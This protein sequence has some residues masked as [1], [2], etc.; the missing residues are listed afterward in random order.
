MHLYLL[1]RGTLRAVREWR[2]GLS[3]CYLPMEVKDKDGKLQKAMAQL[4][5]R[6]VELYE[7][8]FPE[9]HEATV[10]GLVKPNMD[11]SRIG[12]MWGRVGKW[13]IKKFGLK[14][15]IKDWEPSQLPPNPGMSI[16]A[17]GTKKDIINWTK[18][19]GPQSF[20]DDGSIPREML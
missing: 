11:I 5:I 7:I 14:A 1:T 19:Q 16:I 18:K 10:M 17:L 15:P 2:E 13:L 9:E 8:V 3:N 6:P 4:Q 20:C 12:K